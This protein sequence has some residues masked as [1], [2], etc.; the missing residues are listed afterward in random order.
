MVELNLYRV[1]KRDQTY[2]SVYSRDGD[3]I[4]LFIHLVIK[5]VMIM[6][7]ARKVNSTHMC[8]H[9]VAANKFTRVKYIHR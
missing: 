6:S 4:I 1:S 8:I 5:F 9:G 7:I 2:R 3:E